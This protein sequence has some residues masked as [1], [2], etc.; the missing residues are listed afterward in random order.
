MEEKN[1][2]LDRYDKNLV[3]RSKQVTFYFEN[4]PVT[5]YEGETIGVALWANWIRYIDDSMK[6]HRPR[7]LMTLRPIWEMV[8]V[9]VNGVPH[10]NPAVELVKDGVVVEKQSRIS[11]LIKAFVN[12]IDISPT[13]YYIE[14][15]K[16]RL[17]RNLMI[18]LSNKIMGV[19]ESPKSKPEI[20]QVREMVRRKVDVVILGASYSGLK[21]AK[22][23]S[24]NDLSVSIIT[25]ER[26]L[27][28]ASY[29][30]GK[31][32]DSLIQLIEELKSKDNVAIS[33]ESKVVGLHENRDVVVLERM[34][35]GYQYSIY[36]NKAVVIAFDP[37]ERVPLFYNNDLPG[38][39]FAD[40]AYRLINIYGVKPGDDVVIL[41]AGKTG[42][43][44]ASKLREV[45]VNVKALVDIAGEKPVDHEN[46]YWH[47]TVHR[48]IGD[49]NIKAVEIAKVDSSGRPLPDSSIKLEC[50]TLIIATG[51]R[52]L[53]ELP[54]QLKPRLRYVEEIDSFA[55]IRNPYF[56]TTVKGLYV[57]GDIIDFDELELHEN[58]AELA[59]IGIL[60][61]LGKAKIEDATE[62]IE[63]FHSIIE[64]AGLMSAYNKVIVEQG[65]GE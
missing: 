40:M 61:N 7:G 26:F 10:V 65:G 1:L 50:D 58:I 36:E 19:P 8:H 30:R 15:A 49:F 29:Y 44:L 18:S 59:S 55:P 45:G 63:E 34:D 51:F 39:I 24:E 31:N 64:D 6:Y 47:H 4:K 37:V 53:F 27:G 42:L 23:L 52:P 12:R 25:P 62:R 46:V 13:R 16:P 56:E 14:L 5:G 9:R 28:G 43:D 21:L 38:I 48:A 2:R 32:K 20:V 33:L 54:S 17:L 57:I 22:L 11:P 3:D 35:H 60:K 41:G